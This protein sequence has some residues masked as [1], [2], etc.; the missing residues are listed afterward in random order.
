MSGYSV[1]AWLAL[2]LADCVTSG[3]ALK[4][5]HVFESTSPKTAPLVLNHWQLISR[6][7][8]RISVD[9][10]LFPLKSASGELQGFSLAFIQPCDHEDPNER[11]V[12]MNK[13]LEGNNRD[14]EQVIARANNMALEAEIARIQLNQ[15]FNT[16]A[17]SMWVIDQIFT[18]QRVNDAMVAKLG[19]EK[20]EIIGNK[21]YELMPVSAC[22]GP[23]C[24][25]H[26]IHQG[27]SRV[28]CD[29]EHICKDGHATPYI[30]TATPFLG[31]GAELIGIVEAFKD[32]TRRK[33]AEA[34]LKTAN[35]ELERL[36]ATDALT[37]VANRRFF[38]FTLNKEWKRLRRER[39]PLSL[40]MCDVDFFKLYNDEYGHQA[41]DRCLSAVA[42]VI[43]A[44]IRRPGDLAARYGGEEFAAVLPNTHA[45]GAEY[46]AQCIRRGVEAL[47]IFHAKSHIS[48]F[49]TLSLGVCTLI[50]DP[51]N[52]PELLIEAAD[53]A[54][55]HAKESGRN[56]VVSK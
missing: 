51:S 27:A 34:A 7:G 56:R 14:L 17:D 24:P 19:M 13:M 6:D 50:P 10:I 42:R 21:C 22:H 25:M 48:S 47:E 54:L 35:L 16:F 53:Q 43:Q 46:V 55:Y 12:A 40:I 23:Q 4:L 15:I 8:E 3:T 32:I 2:N 26:R 41:G 45:R 28:E 39:Q 29:T 20:D 9:I 49:V 5:S 1:D 36:A 37:Q 33:E 30:L 38:D 18:I 52:S 11:L 44:N 31:L